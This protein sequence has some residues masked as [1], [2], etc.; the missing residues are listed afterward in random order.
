MH[1]LISARRVGSRPRTGL[2]HR[3]A[4][5]KLESMREPIKSQINHRRGVQRQQ[6]AQDQATDNGDSQGP[7]QFRSH[8]RSQRQRQARQQR[9]HSSHHDRAETQQARF[10]NGVAAAP[11]LLDVRLPEQSQSS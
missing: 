7:T 6:L 10:V 2:F 8:A 4:N 1:W 9:R 11:C 5:A 3:I